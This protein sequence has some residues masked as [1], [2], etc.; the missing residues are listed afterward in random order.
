MKTVGLRGPKRKAVLD[1]ERRVFDGKAFAGR[2]GTL[3]ARYGYTFNQVCDAVEIAPESMYRYMRGN[4]E[5]RAVTMLE[6]SRLLHVSPEW[7]IF[8]KGDNDET[9]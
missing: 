2:L 6:L 8:G 9:D 1:F 3:I 5:P 7:L 4:T